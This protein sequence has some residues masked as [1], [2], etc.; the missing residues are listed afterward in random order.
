M[1]TAGE[2]RVRAAQSL[3]QL[4][5][6]AILLEDASK[7][8]NPSKISPG[9]PERVSSILNE[10][11]AVS[12]RDDAERLLAAGMNPSFSSFCYSFQEKLDR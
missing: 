5:E 2:E 11:T 7:T 10:L 12:S 9:F 6:V 3:R 4:E 1:E 8:Q